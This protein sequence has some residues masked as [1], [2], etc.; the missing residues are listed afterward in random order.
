MNQFYK[1]RPMNDRVRLCKKDVCIEAGG[2]NGQLM[3]AAF[4][5]LLISTAAY[6]ISKIK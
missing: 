3:V 6:Y 1:Y 4:V 5:I 2:L